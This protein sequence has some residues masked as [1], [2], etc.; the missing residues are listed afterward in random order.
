MKKRVVYFDILKVISCFLVILIHVI[1]RN[2]YTLELKSS[3]FLILTILDSICRCAVPIYFMISGAIFLDQNKDI[4]I[5]DILKKY[6]LNIFLIF[7]FW[8]IIYSVLDLIINKNEIINF[9]VIKNIFISTITGKGI[10]HLNFLV[11]IIGF[12]LCVPILRQITKKENKKI[13][14]YFIILLFIF[15]CVPSILNLFNINLKYPILFTGFTL[16]FILGYYLNTF[17]LKKKYRYIIYFWGII[18]L[19]LTP[20]LTMNDSLVSNIHSEKY[21]YYGSF[22]IY[23]YSAS[24]FLLFKEIFKNKEES[25]LLQE[26]SKIYFGVYLIHGLVLGVLIKCGIFNIN[27][28]LSVKTIIISLIVF[29]ISFMC[30]FIISKIPLIKRLIYVK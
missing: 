15:T 9:N 18:C 13:I 6:V 4:K 20:I 14:E 17:E 8:N 16:Y 26:M 1:S 3:N 2:W 22:N 30:S 28:N 10:F 23:I 29:I 24:L 7:I 12:Y 19:V 27:I 5:K 21:F 11:I 25:K